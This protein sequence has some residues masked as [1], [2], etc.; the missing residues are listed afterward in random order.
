MSTAEDPPEQAFQVDLS[1]LRP[2]PKDFGPIEPGDI[3]QTR[4]GKLYLVVSTPRP[5]RSWR[6]SECMYYFTLSQNG[7]VERSGQVLL[8]YAE[9]NWIKVGH[10]H[11]TFG[12]PEWF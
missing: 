6:T 8:G 7:V 9:Q 12:E 11:I 2:A 3:M 1:G 10:M 4:Q 5:S